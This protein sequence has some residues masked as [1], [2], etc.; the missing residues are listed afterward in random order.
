MSK[1]RS[2]AAVLSL[3]FVLS[4]GTAP[5]ATI[6]FEP[7]EAQLLNPE[8]G[9]MLLMNVNSSS[10]STLDSMRSNG[11]TVAWGLIYLNKNEQLTPN[12]P[13][14]AEIRNWLERVRANRLKAIVRVV[15]HQNT[16]FDSPNEASL[17]QIENHLT[18][19]Q[20]PFFDYKDVIAAHQAGLFGAYGEWYY[21]PHTS[22][23][24]R[25]RILD[26][27]FDVIPSD[28][29]L[30]VRTSYYKSEYQSAGGAPSRV[31]RI[32]H[33]N[34]CF[35]QGN[36]GTEGYTCYPESDDCLSVPAWKNTI[37]VDSVTVPV[38]GETCSD[39]RSI[40]AQAQSDLRTLGWTYIN[41]AWW[42]NSS[43]NDTTI[44]EYWDALP[45]CGEEI[46]KNLGYR[47]EL[48][49]ATLPDV[50]EAGQEAQISVTLRNTGYAPIYSA[51]AVY[52]RLLDSSN[53][54]V[55]TFPTNQ[56]P[57]T[58]LPSVGDITFTTDIL[59]PPQLLQSSV[60]VAL[61]IPDKEVTLSAVPEYSVRFASLN[62][63]SDV[64]KPVAGGV[65]IISESVSTSVSPSATPCIRIDGSFVDWDEPSFTDAAGDSQDA[66]TDFTSGW[67]SNDDEQLYLRFQTAQSQAFFSSPRNNIFIDTDN[68]PATGYSISGIG[69]ELMIQAGQGYDQRGGG[70]NEGT[71]TGLG[72]AYSPTGSTTD[73]EVEISRG[74]RYS[75]D[76]A[77]VFIGTSIRIVLESENTDFATKEV[78]PD[79]GGFPYTIAPNCGQTESSLWKISTL[80][81]QAKGAQPS[82]S[83][84]EFID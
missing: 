30:M 53:N 2:L 75:K 7:S 15:Y 80:S 78:A 35:L 36:A 56:D 20:Q 21:T 70:F 50:L 62:N 72:L 46:R 48:R 19:L 26:K 84:A 52:L 8:R 82:F 57:R 10:L 6:Q 64:W 22:A 45:G 1:I 61:W 44:F 54:V 47:F 55:A 43:D 69:S 41:T 37:A 49:S 58:W 24:D 29:F 17:L 71:V 27:L 77:P 32:G 73:R 23:A 59:V 16:A 11:Y 68:N 25:K 28:A 38:G 51:R 14:L 18:Q 31:A 79:S 5:A 13:R 42:A 39:V 40:C 34:D 66:V 3:P 60:Q 9:V 33:Y 83:K 76:N 81:E 4:L 65:N 74:A 12:S 67:V 63:G